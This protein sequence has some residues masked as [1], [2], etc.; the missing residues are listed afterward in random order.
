M[1]DRVSGGCLCGAIRFEAAA[2]PA[3][4]LL[5]HCRDCQTVS[6]SAMYAAY[7]VL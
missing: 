6:G 3:F 5:C 4:Q 1:K 2:N 7:V